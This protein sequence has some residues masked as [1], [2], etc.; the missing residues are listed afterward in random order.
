MSPDCGLLEKI[1]SPGYNVW[2]ILDVQEIVAELMKTIDSERGK[3]L[4]T[5]T[6]PDSY[7]QS[8]A[9]DQGRFHHIGHLS[10]ATGILSN[11]Q[12]LSDWTSDLEL[13]NQLF[14]ESFIAEQCLESG[15]ISRVT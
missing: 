11:K 8:W 5:G 14:S 9:W 7:W 6:Q 3:E 15:Q 4:L 12:V 13:R 1:H 10:S 2:H